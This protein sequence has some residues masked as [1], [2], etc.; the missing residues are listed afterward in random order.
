MARR[1]TTGNGTPAAG[2]TNGAAPADRI[3]FVEL[4]Q[5][6][7]RRYLNYALSVITS[8]ALPDVRDGL[9]PVQRRILYVMY[10]ELRLTAEAKRRKSM[11]ICGDTTG[12]YHPHGDVAV[13]ETL[14]R[15]AQDFT[16]RYPLVDGQGNFGSILGL[17]HAAARYTEI[18][19][20]AIAEQLMAEL[21]YQTVDM[22]PNYDGT[23]EE[24]VVLPARFPN[25]LVNGTQGIAVGM[26]TNIPPHNL[27]EVVKACI[28]LIKHKDAT[29]G[30]LMQY[31]KGPDFPL[32]GRVV[33]DRRTL[34]KCYKYG[35]GSIKVRGEWRFDRQGR[36]ELN[37]RLVIHSVP[38]GVST[39][40]LL[41]QLGEITG[42]RKLPQLLGSLDETSEENGLRIVLEIKPGTHDAVMAYLYKHTALEQNFAFNMTCL[43]PDDQGLPVPRRLSLPEMLRYFLDFRFRTVRRRFEYQL[44]QL[45]KRIHIL[46]GFEIVFNGLDEALKI[47]RRSK[48][49]ADAAEKLMKAFPLDEDQTNAILE[50][51]LYRISQLEIDRI[52]EELADKRAQAERIRQILA[53]DA[54][55]WKVVQKELQEVS[56]TFGDRRK[57]AIGSAEEVTEYDPQAY[58]VRENTNVVVTRDGWIKRVGRLQNVESTRVREGDAVI[59]VV[60]GSTLEHVVFL[61]S[62][63]VAYTLRI[64]DVPASSGYGEPL[65][66]HVRLA[67]GAGVIGTIT[68]DPRFT[69]ADKK[70]RGES[71][72]APYVLVA[73]AQGQVLRMPLSPF[74][75]PS[76][77][78]GRKYCRLRKGDRV[79]YA[80]LVGDAETMFL[81][82]RNARVIHFKINDVPVLSAAGKGVRGIKL[83]TGDQVL[84]AVQL[85]RPS[86]CL[87]AVNVHDK[88][89]TFGQMK[90]GV[91]SRG[92]KG[93]RTSQRTGFKEILRPPIELV[94]WSEMEE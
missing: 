36:K 90:Y 86:D 60:P 77:R 47:I 3:E 1:K 57:T 64:A 19:L 62:D 33:S 5:E 27:G 56:D 81:A 21:R 23:R 51:Q 17:P 65:S 43:V 45:E 79:V 30:R 93:V 41:E 44:R 94:D 25:L 11:K 28:Y 84:G 85:S 39:G 31:V 4:S 59:D 78:N 14:V 8:R 40:P 35:R 80:G 72:P 83:E 75:T 22:R 49:K 50:L 26:A 38:Y 74:R 15:M 69:P 88:P 48:G 68:T 67:D 46:E 42:S 6:T 91:T 87:R 37:D 73:T 13:Y 63:G 9:K 92:G 10:Q 12:N 89:L 58:I 32:G 52:R 29:V 53:S 71:A 76:T 20:T 34:G 2:A 7:R 18:R 82:T 55:L 70:V 66:K 54:R 24:P 16:L 61:A